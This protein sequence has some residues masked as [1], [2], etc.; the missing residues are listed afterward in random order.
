MSDE[1]IQDIT[2]VSKKL[3]IVILSSTRNVITLIIDK[4]TKSLRMRSS[5]YLIFYI[6]PLTDNR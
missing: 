3:P 5:I 1:L 2:R 4:K 6:D